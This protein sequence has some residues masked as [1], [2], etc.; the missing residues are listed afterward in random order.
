MIQRQNQQLILRMQNTSSIVIAFQRNIIF[1]DILKY[2][3]LKIMETLITTFE[4]LL[5]YTNT[6]FVR[7]LYSDVA[8]NNR[9]IGIIGAKGTGKSTLLLQH[10]KLHFPDTSKA[11]YASLDNIW[12]TQHSL[13]ELA[14]DFYNLGG[15]HL[16]LDEVH[17]YPSWAMEIKNI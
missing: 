8:W 13:L 15:T 9:L 6:N 12:F 2:Q 10:I 14:E 5:K 1:A 16:F 11:L 17:K 4:R 3:F 7:Y